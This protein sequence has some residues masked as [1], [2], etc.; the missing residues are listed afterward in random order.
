MTQA[1]KLTTTTGAQYLDKNATGRS[2]PPAIGISS[3][4]LG[5]PSLQKEG[6]YTCPNY[7]PHRIVAG[8]SEHGSSGVPAWAPPPSI[9]AS[10][11]A[12]G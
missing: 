10:S 5:P 3:P 6:H 11:S 12:A 1:G 2:G 4:S 9:S 8:A 7:L